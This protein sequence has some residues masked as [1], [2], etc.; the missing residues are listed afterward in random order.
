MQTV[1]PDALDQV[2]QACQQHVLLDAADPLARIGERVELASVE[3]EANVRSP[4]HT[5]SRTGD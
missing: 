1:A 5:A 3:V 4:E 2:A